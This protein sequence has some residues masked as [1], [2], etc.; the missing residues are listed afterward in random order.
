MQMH[1]RDF[2]EEDDGGHVWCLTW[3]AENKRCQ[4]PK[5]QVPNRSTGNED[6]RKRKLNRTNNSSNANR[7]NWL[8]IQEIVTIII[9]SGAIASYSDPFHALIQFNSIQRVSSNSGSRT[10]KWTLIINLPVEFNRNSQWNRWNNHKG[11]ELQWPIA[12]APQIQ[13]GATPI[14]LCNAI[15]TNWTGQWNFKSFHLVN[16]ATR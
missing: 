12:P 7:W 15:Q 6:Q 2:G 13:G 8:R 16:T 1:W 11:T 5:F 9:N 3:N 10:S 14:A 4:L